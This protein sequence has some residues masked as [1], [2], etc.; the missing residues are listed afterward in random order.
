MVRDGNFVGV[1]CETEDG[2]EAALTRLRKGAT[3]SVGEALPDENDW[4]HG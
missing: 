4:P 2:A 3:W 1:V